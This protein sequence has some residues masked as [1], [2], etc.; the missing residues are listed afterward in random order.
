MPELIEE[1][2]IHGLFHMHSRYS[3]GKD[4]IMEIA[5]AAKRHGYSYI[6]ITDH[7]QVAAYAGGMKVSALFAQQ[8]DIDKVNAEVKGFRVF[9]GAEVDILPDGSLDY[10]DEILK[11]LDF[12]V[13]SIH[14]KFNMTEEEAT[15]RV[16]KAMENPHLTILGHPTGRLLLGRSGY[17]AEHEKGNRRGGEAERRDRTKRPPAEARH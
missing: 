13:C 9:K 7:S 11:M 4:E 3:D 14:S 12:T 8:E 17:P 15:K 2:D 1:K 16:I 6:G 10:P 5:Q